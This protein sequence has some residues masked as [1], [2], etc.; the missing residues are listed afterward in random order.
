M[1]GFV[2]YTFEWFWYYTKL[3]FRMLFWLFRWLMIGISWVLNRRQNNVPSVKSDVFDD[4]KQ[5]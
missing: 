3:T 5:R 2:D 4:E 1:N